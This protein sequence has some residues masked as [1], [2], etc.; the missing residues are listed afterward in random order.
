MTD[1]T[2]MKPFPMKL[3]DILSMYVLP[4][5]LLEFLATKAGLPLDGGPRFFEAIVVSQLFIIPL[6]FFGESLVHKLSSKKPGVAFYVTL[7]GLNCALTAVAA[8]LMF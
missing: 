4:V 5:I 3:P 1:E 8:W 6:R 7:A 2:P